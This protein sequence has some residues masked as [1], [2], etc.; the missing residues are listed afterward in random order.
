MDN[1]VC[2][3]TLPAC[4]EANPLDFLKRRVAEHAHETPLQ[5]SAIDGN[6]LEQLLHAQTFHRVQPDM[7]QRG[8]NVGILHR[9][10]IGRLARHHFRGREHGNLLLLCLRAKKI[11]QH[12]HR[13]AA[14]LLGAHPDARKRRM[15]QLAQ[16]LFIVHAQNRDIIRH[17]QSA[18]ARRLHQLRAPQIIGREDRDR[19]F[20]ATPATLPSPRAHFRATLP[21]LPAWHVRRSCETKTRAGCRGF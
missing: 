14:D 3:S 12:R 15:R 8:G 5:R 1:S 2:S 9:K 4:S 17:A 16:K 21:A 6:R 13:G 11:F 20:A 7:P 10:H 18:L 19:R